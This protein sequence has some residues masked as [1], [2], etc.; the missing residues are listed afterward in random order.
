MRKFAHYGYIAR[1]RAGQGLRAGC[2]DNKSRADEP[3]ADE[4][5]ADEPRADANFGVEQTQSDDENE[6][7]K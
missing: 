4:L 7:D 3:R 2:R 1:R 6:A 5:R